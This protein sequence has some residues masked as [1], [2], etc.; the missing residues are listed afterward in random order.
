MIKLCIAVVLTLAAVASHAQAPATVNDG[1]TFGRSM[2]PTSASQLVGPGAAQSGAWAGNASTPTAPIPRLGA[3]S[4]PN[5]SRSN[6]DSAQGI[7]LLNLGNQAVV[8]CEVYV[9]GTNPLQD[10]AC[11]AVNFLASKCITPTDSQ[12][13]IVGNTGASTQT[14]TNCN[15][16]Y[17]AGMAQYNF[18]NAVTQNDTMFGT[19]GDLRN[20]A[21]GTVGEVCSPTTTVTSPAEYALQSCMSNGLASEHVCSQYLSAEIVITHPQVVE[22]RSCPP[23]TILEGTACVTQ[24]TQPAVP[25]FSCLDGWQAVTP[26]GG[27]ISDIQCQR[28]T[29]TVAS[30]TLSCNNQGVLQTLALPPETECGATG[31][32]GYTNVAPETGYVCYQ[33]SGAVP[34]GSDGASFASSWCPSQQRS[35]TYWFG[36][37]T[38][39][40][41][42]YLGLICYFGPTPI[43]TCPTGQVYSGGQCVLR[44]TSVATLTGYTCPQGT[45][46]GT[47]CTITTSQPATVI[48]TCPEGANLAPDAVICTRVDVTP[49]WTSTCG[50]YETSSG[51][52]LPTP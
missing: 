3:F 33:T 34:W 47:S 40:A 1:T 24:R 25:Q 42:G 17:G 22:T 7:G 20:T 15:G 46:N 35:G 13:R 45:L 36:Y 41:G 37:L 39:N 11:A 16:T 31:C 12:S 4:S 5:T 9:V 38:G 21:R 49:T 26:P 19:T 6:F 50:A 8:D 43:F 28:T 51:V 2:A 52:A 32:V 30:S 29:T 23:G 27:S 44:E 18:Q 14:A 48:N 10:Q